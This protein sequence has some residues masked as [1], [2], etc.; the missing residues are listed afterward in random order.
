MA[1]SLSLSL[2]F[3]TRCLFSR[4]LVYMNISVCAGKN[5][6][7]ISVVSPPRDTRCTVDTGK[8]QQV[9]RVENGHRNMAL[10]SCRYTSPAKEA[11]GA[12]R[13]KWSVL[14]SQIHYLDYTD[15]DAAV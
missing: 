4:G 10:Q 12:I 8:N 7:S 5:T 2:S 15:L 3:F 1:L 14:R 13:K 6:V 9:L 11:V